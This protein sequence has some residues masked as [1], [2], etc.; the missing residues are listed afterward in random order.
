VQ[1]TPTTM[2]PPPQL[3]KDVIQ[4]ILEEFFGG[5]YDYINQAFALREKL[6]CTWAVEWLHEQS[7]KNI[8]EVRK[9][10]WGDLI[11]GLEKKEKE[12]PRSAS[13][14]VESKI[15]NPLRNRSP[16]VADDEF[17]KKI[18]KGLATDLGVKD[19]ELK[20][21][22]FTPEQMET[23]KKG[24]DT[25]Y[26][27]T[28]GLV[29]RFTAYVGGII[30]KWET[31]QLHSPH[32]A[33][34]QSSG[35]GKS[36]LISEY[37][38]RVG[39]VMYCCLRKGV[40]TG[41]PPRTPADIPDLIAKPTLDRGDNHVRHYLSYLT[42]ILQVYDEL[43][44]RHGFSTGE[45]FRRHALLECAD[46]DSQETHP[47][48]IWDC[49]R[50]HMEDHKKTDNSTDQMAA[51]FTKAVRAAGDAAKRPVVFVFDEAR[52]LSAP[53]DE[54]SPD[55]T[56]L[57]YLRRAL[58]KSPKDAMHGCCAVFLDTS[59]RVDT[60]L[61]TRAR[62]PSLRYTNKDADLECPFYLIDTFDE[63]ARTGGRTLRSVDDF[64][65]PDSLTRFGR[66]MWTTQTKS[67]DIIDTA[68]YKLVYGY[69][70]SWAMEESLAV[71][72]TRMLL[73]I[74][75]RTQ[76]A[77]DLVGDHM[78]CCVFVSPARDFVLTASPS[79]P[80]LVEAAARFMHATVNASDPHLSRMLRQL[81]KA[82]LTG[83]VEAGPRGEL[84]A[85]IIL[86]LAAD[87]ACQAKGLG[88][89]EFL[90]AKKLTV[91]EYLRSL[92]G[93]A[94]LQ[95]VVKE[96][97]LNE[98]MRARLFGASMFLTHIV[99]ARYIPSREV[100]LRFMARGAA[101][102]C[103]RNQPG[104]DIVIP[105]LL[106]HG[107][108]AEPA[109]VSL[110][111]NYRPRGGRPASSASSTA[112]PDITMSQEGQQ[113]VDEEN[114]IHIDPSRV[115]FIIVQVKNYEAGGD[116][117]RN[118]KARLNL[119]PSLCVAGVQGDQP[120]YVNDNDGIPYVGIW[121]QMANIKGQIAGLQGIAMNRMPTRA[122]TPVENML[123]LITDGVG[124]DTFP[125]LSELPSM[126]QASKGMHPAG[127][128]GCGASQ[129]PG[130]GVG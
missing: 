25:S 110:I 55:D 126:R 115:S 128:G 17:S 15:L 112:A 20:E 11:K 24:F 1:I 107:G 19:I 65:D 34:V 81:E 130:F 69:K 10:A 59:S 29:G 41:Y 117:K 124:P 37:A 113:T 46:D 85:R 5:N 67:D 33:I 114:V 104:V 98:D 87:H 68:Q 51:T 49:V 119:R 27:D 48:V 76:L 9:N 80:V 23:I 32:G 50:A 54:R 21:K 22:V 108:D 26:R 123:G 84:V 71:L 58:A 129:Q 100:L 82:L 63:L 6:R 35:T 56:F 2:A 97:D 95:A 53:I 13:S 28:S 38:S 94:N 4:P 16:A 83:F 89:G 7:G 45:W 125:F 105:I 99:R 18:A 121:M 12:E 106:P 70:P 90:Y 91:D 74:A 93:P 88:G 64:C 44:Q 62:D 36:R 109:A 60:F 40:S 127:C 66:P 52:A 14:I 118:K 3:D 30:S 102:M 47:Q 8:P 86:L 120:S 78:R 57:R 122:V 79:E 31:S 77:S 101:V 116:D 61:P 39:L 92:I 96:S 73:D 111:P 42:A 72:G 75:P 103:Q 43:A